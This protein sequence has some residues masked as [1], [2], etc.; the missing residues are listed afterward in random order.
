MSDDAPATTPDHRVIDTVVLDLGQVLVDWNPRLAHPHLAASEWDAIA[1]EID[2]HAYNLRADGGETWES[3][4][5][6]VAG[7]W[8]QHAGFLTAY[9]E[10]FPDT[11]LGPVAGTEALVADLRAVGV[12]LL[13]L[14]NW[15]VQTY[16][17]GVTAAPAIGELEAVV[18]SGAVGLIKPEPAIFL[19]LVDAHDVDPARAVFV[20][21][22]G[23]N[24]ATAQ[25]LGFTGHV[26]TDAA[27]LRHRLRALGVAIPAA[28]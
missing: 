17:H 12:R 6:E 22:R 21:D 27:S 19:H 4:D 11:L 25:A 9:L 13:G 20:D 10:N 8:P 28:T 3:L 15:S 1:D 26:F 18:V 2:F 5:A 7:T 24:V 16:P 14:S 23:E